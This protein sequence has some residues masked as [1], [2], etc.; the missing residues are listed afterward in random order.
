VD[1]L[2]KRVIEKNPGVVFIEFAINDAFLKYATPSI[3]M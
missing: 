3:E 1:N 2:D